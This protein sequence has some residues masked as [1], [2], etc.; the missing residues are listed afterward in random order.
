MFYIVEHG[1]NFHTI[2]AMSPNFEGLKEVAKQMKDGSG[3]HFKIIE[4]KNIWTTIS[5][6]EWLFV[7]NDH[8]LEIKKKQTTP[9]NEWYFYP[10]KQTSVKVAPPTPTKATV[11]DTFENYEKHLSIFYGAMPNELKHL[12]GYIALNKA[13]KILGTQNFV[14]MRLAEEGKIVMRNNGRTGN[15]RRYRI[16]A[17]DLRRLFKV[18]QGE[19][20]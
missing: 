15:G 11:T 20:A 8:N 18:K 1:E 9:I 13:S 2:L 19:T 5:P 3:C 14:L 10:K 17:A 7:S 6:D 16:P 4:I 12:H